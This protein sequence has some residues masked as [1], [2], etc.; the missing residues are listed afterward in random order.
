MDGWKSIRTD[1]VIDCP[2]YKWTLEEFR[3]DADQQMLFVHLD[4]HADMTL[5]LLKRMQ[6]EW[7]LFRKHVPCPVFAC[8]SHDD[9]KFAAFVKLFGFKPLSQANCTDGLSRRIYWHQGN[10]HFN[11]A[12]QFE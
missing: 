9:E 7:A 10:G 4:V 6:Y 8:G 3:N 12:N 2:E 1:T 11:T 5:K